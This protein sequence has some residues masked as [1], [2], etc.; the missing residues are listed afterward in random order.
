MNHSK[1]V[2]LQHETPNVKLYGPTPAGL[3]VAIICGNNKH[4][5]PLQPVRIT[6]LHYS[7]AV[8]RMRIRC[9]CRVHDECVYEFHS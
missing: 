8:D 5:E 7:G 9:P 1:D 3:G 2:L 4:G 6:S